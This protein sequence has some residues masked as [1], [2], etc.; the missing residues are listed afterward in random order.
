M[1][2]PPY[3]LSVRPATITLACADNGLGIQH[4]TWTSWTAD[5]ATGQGTL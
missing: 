2:A 5:A 1:S 4:M 3:P